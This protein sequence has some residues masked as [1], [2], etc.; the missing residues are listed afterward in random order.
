M[1]DW[2]PLFEEMPDYNQSFL[3]RLTPQ[4]LTVNSINHKRRGQNVLFGD[5]RVV[6]MKKRMI[7]ADDIYTLQDTDVYKGCEVPSCST[8]FF[9]AP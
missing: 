1:A 8:D 6:Y 4:L 9:L 5:G 7:G 3:K 2:N